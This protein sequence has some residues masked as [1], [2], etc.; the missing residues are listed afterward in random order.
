M[1]GEEVS[2]ATNE[3][4]SAQPCGLGLTEAAPAPRPHAPKQL[5]PRLSLLCVFVCRDTKTPGRRH[6]KATYV[7]PTAIT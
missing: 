2:R 6:L 1:S 7:K 5:H 3:V 4:T